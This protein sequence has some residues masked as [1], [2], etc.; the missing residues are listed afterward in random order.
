MR[1][2]LQ[3]SLEPPADTDETLL[4]RFLRAR[5]FKVADAFKMLK[6]DLFWR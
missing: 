4:L 6:E 2:L 5:G 1:D 3:S